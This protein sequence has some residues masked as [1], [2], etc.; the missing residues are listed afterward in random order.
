MWP[1]NVDNMP[2]AGQFK[3]LLGNGMMPTASGFIAAS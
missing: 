2:D 1:D 3:P